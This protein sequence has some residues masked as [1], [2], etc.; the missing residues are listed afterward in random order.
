[1]RVFLSA[2]TGV[3][4]LISVIA[5]NA[6]AADT[7]IEISRVK[8]RHP[9]YSIDGRLSEY[10]TDYQILLFARYR[11]DPGII[12][13]LMDD[14]KFPILPLEELLENQLPPPKGSNVEWS[15]NLMSDDPIIE[16][17]AVVCLVKDGINIIDYSRAFRFFFQIQNF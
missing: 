11:S 3:V 10:R 15:V 17:Y 7:I 16:L 12:E 14:E 1:M 2:F 4:F 13:L 6:K 9:D 5:F 8:N